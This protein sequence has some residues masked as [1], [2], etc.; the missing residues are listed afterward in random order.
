MLELSEVLAELRHQLI[1][2]QLAGEGS[3]LRFLIDDIEVDLQ[4]VV[5]AEGRAKAGFKVLTFG[6]EAEAK[7]SGATTQKLHLKLKIVDKD[8][9][10]VL[11]SGKDT[12]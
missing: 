4:V 11:I 1:Q 5:T 8:G 3:D 10:S 7:G 2:A 6:A 12:R 9:K